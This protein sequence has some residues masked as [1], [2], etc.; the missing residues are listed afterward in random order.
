MKEITNRAFYWAN[1]P[2]FRLG[3]LF[4]ALITITSNLQAQEDLK[5]K[6]ASGNTLMEV[7]EEGVL[8]T[9]TTTTERTA[10][11][12]MLST[13]DNG[14]MVFD[15]DTQS[16]WIWKSTE[17]VE[18][19]GTDLVDDADADP[20]NEIELPTNPQDGTIAYYE[21]GAWQALTPGTSG[22]VLTM[23]DGAP[24][25]A[26]QS[27]SAC[28]GD[29]VSDQSH[30]TIGFYNQ[31]FS[32]MGQS[33]TA[34]TDGCLTKVRLYLGGNLSTAGYQLNPTIEI[35]E[36]ETISGTAISS[37]EYIPMPLTETSSRQWYEIT[38]S[39]PAE[40]SAGSQYT[41]VMKGNCSPSC[42]PAD[43]IITNTMPGNPYSG[44][45]IIFSNSQ[46]G[47]VDM[48]FETFVTN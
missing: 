29:P 48:P 1:N 44:G 12:T 45:L 10:S 38:F 8:I 27:E 32:S 9:Q 5:I 20:T 11:A 23:I 30:L 40:I 15:T 17:W 22:Q 3:L 13:A 39:S 2:I 42:G 16:F 36:G 18:I 24:T 41:L 34:G 26:D 19:D 4:V 21:S 47:S 35:H 14:L 37:V 43:Y 6:D 28:S 33:F 25:W 31:A 7:R 46:D